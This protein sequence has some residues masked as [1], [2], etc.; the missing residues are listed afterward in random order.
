MAT[1]R[2]LAEAQHKAIEKA[3]QT[4]NPFSLIAEEC[5]S[6][7]KDD[8]KIEIKFF[9]SKEMSKDLQ[10]FCFKL[11]ERNVGAYYK[12]CSLGWQP[13]V[14][15]NDISKNWARFLIAYNGSKPI[16]FTMFRFGKFAGCCWMWFRNNDVVVA[17][18]DYGRSVVYWWVKFSYFPMFSTS[19]K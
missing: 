4:K 5:G 7:Q 1:E 15:Q 8:L 19:L 11:A 10:K 2:E 3:N 12:S 6:Y 17:D 14:K 13:K 9:S 16:G 18:M